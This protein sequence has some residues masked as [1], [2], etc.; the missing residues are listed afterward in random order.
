MILL[1]NTDF[2]ADRDKG[3]GFLPPSEE[4]EVVGRMENEEPGSVLAVKPAANTV[5]AILTMSIPALRVSTIDS[6][7]GRD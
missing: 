1:C 5:S 6:S 3:R 2:A 4:E 7:F